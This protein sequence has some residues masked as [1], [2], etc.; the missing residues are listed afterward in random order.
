MATR[1]ITIEERKAALEAE[2]AQ[3]QR[4]RQVL[5]SELS[6]F[7]TKLEN[8]NRELASHEQK[9]LTQC[10]LEAL[11]QPHQRPTV[12]ADRVT[13]LARQK[14]LTQLVQEKRQEIIVH[15]SVMA[16]VEKELHE[17]LTTERLNELFAALRQSIDE[18][19]K[20]VAEHLR[21]AKSFA[22]RIAAMRE[23]S[24]PMI[25]KAGCDA[26]EKLARAWDGFPG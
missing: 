23:N 6:D 8:C 24:E 3:G 26:A 16:P 7:E 20:E 18:G 10:R 12:E 9:H 13:T 4:K 5:Q 14:G 22:A 19:E 25:R 1:T 2:V 17:I 15:Q 21:I 11:G